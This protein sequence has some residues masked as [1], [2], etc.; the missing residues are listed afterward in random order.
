[1]PQPL[2]PRANRDPCVRGVARARVCECLFALGFTL[3]LSLLQGIIYYYIQTIPAYAAEREWRTIESET[4]EKK[5][6][7]GVRRGEGAFVDDVRSTKTEQKQ[8]IPLFALRQQ[9]S[10][11]GLVWS[12]LSS[13]EINF[14]IDR[15]P[16][17]VTAS[18]LRFSN[19]EFFTKF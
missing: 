12:A 15:D 2:Q 9:P 7:F 17:T 18:S 14:S 11:A 19:F 16:V 10:R 1:M 8:T 13:S 6:A 3:L 4:A 5:K